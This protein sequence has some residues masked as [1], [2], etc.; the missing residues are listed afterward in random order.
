MNNNIIKI[1]IGAV[2]GI[3]IFSFIAHFMYSIFPCRFISFFFPVN[4]SI[5]EHMKIIYTS[6]LLYGIIDY[7]M[8]KISFIKTHNFLLQLFLTSFLSILFYLVLYLPIRYFFGENFS[9]SIVL[10]FVVYSVMQCLSLYLLL[11]SKYPISRQFIIFLIIVIYFLFV[12]F[13]YHP[14]HNMLFYDTHTK[15][16]GIP[17]KRYSITYPSTNLMAASA[18]CSACSYCPL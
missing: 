2:F 1:K 16:Y 10:L 12:F 13:T 7:Y 11:Q 8:L 4:E 18:V 9:V 3:F 14:I 5:F 6:T 15:S 17:V